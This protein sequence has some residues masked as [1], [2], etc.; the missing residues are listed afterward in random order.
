[1]LQVIFSGLAVG[2][3][4]GL[5]AMGFAVA[6]YVTRVINFAQGQLLMAAVMV[7]AAASAA[8]WP[9]AVAAVA[10]L[11]VSTVGG[12]LVYLVAVRPVLAFDR[13]SFAWLVSTLG[14]AIVL[15]SGAAMIWGPT[16]R[17]FPTMLNGTGFRIGGAGVTAQELLAVAVAVAAVA[18]FEV[19]RRRTLFGKLGMAISQDPE[20]ASAVGANTQVVAVVAFALAGLLAGLAGELVGPITFANPYLGDTYGIAGFVALMVG[21]VER[22]AGAMAGGFVLGLLD[23][24]ADRYIDSQASD[25]FPFLIVVAVLLVAPRGMFST[26]AALRRLARRRPTVRGA[27]S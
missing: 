25:W 21:G 2:A 15:S 13:F 4:Y 6:F 9:T 20:M 5:V 26:G 12:V 8:G 27:V 24:V 11:L 14:V 22:P 19:V 18:A 17:T 10:G 1:M 16:S 7:T 23:Q 3:I